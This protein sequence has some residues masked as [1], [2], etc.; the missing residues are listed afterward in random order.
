MRDK[1]LYARI[2]DIEA[3][4]RVAD[5]ELNVQQGEVV[6]HV[7]RSGVMMDSSSWYRDV[8]SISPRSAVYAPGATTRLVRVQTSC[9]SAVWEGLRDSIC[10]TS[11]YREAV[12][13]NCVYV[14]LYSLLQ[15]QS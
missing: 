14:E 15:N 4:W 8:W 12:W 9:R 11:A 13:F 6:V 5:V 2:L 10:Q 7:E 1:E 3:P